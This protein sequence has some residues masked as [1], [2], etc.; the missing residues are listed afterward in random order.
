M[1]AGRC[2]AFQLPEKYSNPAGR[3]GKDAAPRLGEKD[4]P[5]LRLEAAPG[6]FK[7][8]CQSSLPPKEK[9]AQR[10]HWKDIIWKKLP[11]WLPRKGSL[12]SHQE[13]L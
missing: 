12:Q 13:A 2:P 7:A 8:G 3:G 1:P 9:K 4:K 5:I 10:W 11:K 6:S